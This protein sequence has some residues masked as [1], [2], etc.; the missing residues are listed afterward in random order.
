MKRADVVTG[1]VYAVRIAGAMSLSPVRIDSWTKNSFG[2]EHFTGTNMRTGREIRGTAAR[3]R[4][5]WPAG[6][7]VR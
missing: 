4:G 6:E 2:K 7:V 1:K 3:L 5:E